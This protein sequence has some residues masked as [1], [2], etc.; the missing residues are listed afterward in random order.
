[1]FGTLSKLSGS[2]VRPL[3]ARPLRKALHLSRMRPGGLVR[4][5][6]GTFEIF[7]ESRELILS[8][9]YEHE[10]REAINRYLDP[11]SPLLELGGSQGILSCIAN[12]ILKDRSRHV[13]V[14]ANAAVIP[15]L[16]RNRDRNR[17][18]F[19]IIQAAIG[20]QGSSLRFF[21]NNDP[22][23]SSAFIAGS[24]SCDV[25]CLPVAG[26]LDSHGF[27]QCTLICDIEGAE[28]G[29]I[30]SEYRILKERFRLLIIEFH[31]AITGPESVGLALDR[32]RQAGFDMISRKRHVYVLGKEKGRIG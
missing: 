7:P 18:G 22:L 6:T 26:I 29:L 24:Q 27:D 28:I 23:K 25:P 30:D 9:Y 13:V 17:C 10:E 8:G 19:E 20:P 21:Q 15:L 14:E 2:A 5:E 1:M 12:R 32:L 3:I 4:V 31:P 16:R 11:D